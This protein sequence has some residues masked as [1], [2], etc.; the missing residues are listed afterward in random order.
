MQLIWN[1]C[2][3]NVWCPFYEVNL[4]HEHFDRLHGVYMIWYANQSDAKVVYVGKG[5]I[6]QRLAERRSDSRIQSYTHLSLFV[7]WAA[8][9]EA[10]RGGVERYLADTWRPLVG[11]RHP[12]MP[13]IPVNSPW[14]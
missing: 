6:K 2:Q 5:Y 7:T 3:G 14:D 1:K 11:E 8:V 10:S 13:A 4:S 9:D 12:V